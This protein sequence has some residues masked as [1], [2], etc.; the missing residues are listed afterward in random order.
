MGEY[1]FFRVP[2]QNSN[3]DRC[4]GEF[5]NHIVF[6]ATRD[7]RGGK[8]RPNER[9]ADP[10]AQ[11]PTLHRSAHQPQV[12]ERKALTER[13]IRARGIEHLP[14]G[15][16]DTRW[17]RVL[18]DPIDRTREL[19][20]RGTPRRHRGMSTNTPRSQLYRVVRLLSRDDECGR[21]VGQ[22]GIPVEN[23]TTLIEQERRMD[24]ALSK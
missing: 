3:V 11:Q 15:L 19:S 5:R 8:G 22:K 12:A 4:L 17:H 21:H 6:D 2:G 24:S 9:R 23:E 16:D 20:D 10:I 18:F 1:V 13:D 14:N 7:D